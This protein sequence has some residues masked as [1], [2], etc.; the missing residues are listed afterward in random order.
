VIGVRPGAE[1]P[2]V[3]VHLAVGAGEIQLAHGASAE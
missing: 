1:H 3:E 2:K